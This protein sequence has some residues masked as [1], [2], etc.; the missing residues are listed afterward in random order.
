MAET[1]KPF[2][3][4]D[5]ALNQTQHAMRLFLDWQ[6]AKIG[7]NTPRYARLTYIEKAPDASNA[8]LVWQI[9]VKP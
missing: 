6:M 5:H 1:F 2:E 8:M 3:T 4:L 7:L 9:F